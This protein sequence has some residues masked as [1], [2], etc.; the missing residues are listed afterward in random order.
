MAAIVCAV[1][2]LVHAALLILPVKRREQRIWRRL[3]VQAVRRRLTTDRTG[4]ESHRGGAIAETARRNIRWHL[5]LTVILAATLL[6]P[7]VAA[8]QY[9]GLVY[10][11]AVAGSIAYVIGS[12]VQR[13]KIAILTNREQDARKS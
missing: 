9:R 6:H 3:N 8:F 4:H 1:F 11:F 10:G 7:R 13:Q 2:A 12:I 5:V